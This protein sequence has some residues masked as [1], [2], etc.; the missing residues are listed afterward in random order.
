MWA[1]HLPSM[2]R[3]R[4]AF[5]VRNKLMMVAVSGHPENRAA[6]ERQRSAHRQEI[7]D[8]L[9]CLVT[10]MGEQ[11]V[12]ML[13]PMPRLPEIHHRNMA[14]NSACQVKKNSAAIESPREMRP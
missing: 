13:M 1:H 6:L 10:A 5:L 3:M 14:T 9:G 8:P 11:A 12:I 2:R 4:I 7:F